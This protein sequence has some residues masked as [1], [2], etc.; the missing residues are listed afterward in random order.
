MLTLEDWQ[1]LRATIEADQ[2]GANALDGTP[3]SV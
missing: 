2:S 3:T 1:A